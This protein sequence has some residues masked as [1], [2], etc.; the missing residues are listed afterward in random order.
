VPSDRQLVGIFRIAES[1]YYMVAGK[2]LLGDRK[3]DVTSMTT[4]TFFLRPVRMGRKISFG[5]P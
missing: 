3:T 1:L 2:T 4:L 5:R